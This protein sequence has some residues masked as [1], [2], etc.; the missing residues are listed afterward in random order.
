MIHRTALQD[1][2]NFGHLRAVQSLLTA[3][4]IE[5]NG[6]IPTPL[7][8]AV[9]NGFAQVA[10]A[11]LDTPGV[12]LSVIDDDENNLLHLA[13]ASGNAEIVDDLLSNK[14]PKIQKQLAGVNRYQ[15][16]P[17]LLAAEKPLSDCVAA[18]IR[19]GVANSSQR[20]SNGNTALHLAAKTG[21]FKSIKLILDL[22]NSD[23]NDTNNEGILFLFFNQT[24]LHLAAKRCRQ[25]VLK[26]LLSYNT[27]DVNARDE[28]GRSPLHRMIEG[29]PMDGVEVLLSAKGLDFN[30]QDDDGET[31]LHLA[32]KCN[33]PEYINV[34]LTHKEVNVH[35]LDNNGQT[36]LHKA[37]ASTNYD[38]IKF[39]L[40]KGIDI[41]HQDVHGVTALHIATKAKES[42]IVQAILKEP[43]VE[44]NLP[45]EN[46]QTPL[47]WAAKNGNFNI[48]KAILTN[49]G[50]MNAKDKTGVLFSNVFIN[51]LSIF[52]QRKI[53]LE[54][55]NS[56]DQLHKQLK[57]ENNCFIVFYLNSISRYDKSYDMIEYCC[58]SVFFFVQRYVKI[59]I[60]NW[61]K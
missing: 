2:A 20:D 29:K 37:A 12:D 44:V 52:Y 48:I 25:M 21:S 38:S 43:G 17:F 9:K 30:A 14:S 59:M 24:A 39:L 7:Q 58:L 60:I 42:V 19:C 34:L 45:D 56:S 40:G 4:G 61:H 54:P 51:Y 33:Y 10:M 22:P 5:I 15:Q 8:E 6:D 27:I 47:H 23:I 46:K 1:A 32:A 28:M 26:T 36:P 49:G 50:N 57:V 31:P 16:T 11:I 53:N 3:K 41:N 55:K 35:L 18:F 13:A